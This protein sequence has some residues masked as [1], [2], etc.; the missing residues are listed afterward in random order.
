MDRPTVDCP[1]PL[2]HRIIP[3]VRAARAVSVTLRP[4]LLAPGLD[5]AGHQ[6]GTFVAIGEIATVM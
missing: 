6:A 3:Q 1:A 5:D 4:A 2:P